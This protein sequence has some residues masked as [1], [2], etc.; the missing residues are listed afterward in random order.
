MKLI[1]NEIISTFRINTQLNEYRLICSRSEQLLRLSF[2]MDEADS[3]LPRDCRDQETSL[4]HTTAVILAQLPMV[5]QEKGLNTPSHKAV[6]RPSENGDFDGDCRFSVC[7]SLQET[8]GSDETSLR[9]DFYRRC[10]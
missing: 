5:Q 3:H 9:S 4:N 6:P 10:L 7:S 2:T 8:G 1:F